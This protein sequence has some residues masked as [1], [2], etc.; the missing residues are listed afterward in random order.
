MNLHVL[1]LI[2]GI[3][4]FLYGIQ[5]ACY[6]LQQLAGSQLKV[7][8]SQLTHNRLKS[9]VTGMGV[10]ALL[11]SSSASSVLVV[12]FVGLGLM[13]FD[14]VL[15]FLLGAG[16]GS[17][18]T[19]QLISF[20]IGKYALLLIAVGFFISTVYK[21]MG[22]QLGMVIFG[23]GLVFFSMNLMG[24]ATLTF[25]ENKLFLDLLKFLA[26]SPF[27]AFIFAALFTAL[28]QGSAATLG[29]LI[30]LGSA[31]VLTLEE[32]IPFM[33][34]ANVGTCITA[35]IA[36]LKS[37]VKGRQV[38]FAFLFF[39]TSGALL[40][41]PF[42]FLFRD[43]VVWST[44]IAESV[45]GE[46]A[47]IAHQIAN[48]H[49]FFNFIN[50]LIFLPGLGLWGK[51]IQKIFPTPLKK[52]EFG[53]LYLDEGAISSPSFALGQATR[54]VLRVGE[55]V[56][57]ML[58]G[59]LQVLKVNDEELMDKINR[60][61]DK[62]DL[63]NRNIK[64]YLARITQ[65]SLTEEQACIEHELVSLSS[66][67]EHVGDTITKNILRIIEKKK[68]KQ[69]EFSKD[70]L[71]EIENFYDK[72]LENFKLS[73]SAFAMMDKQLSIKVL[74]NRQNIQDFE[75]ELREKHFQRLSEGQKSTILTTSLHLE[76]LTHLKNISSNIS[77]IAYL[78]VER[79]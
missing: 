60:D 37:S 3:C 56:Q 79:L 1:E 26:E 21:K 55:I 4:L 10:T 7:F 35:L 77:N 54:E 16:V 40:F 49:T 68:R 59:T 11:Q 25:K 36:S 6:H 57:K 2:G 27:F 20:K 43:F 58:G 48:A 53:P 44:S 73:L 19:A 63:L 45:M 5:I 64:F 22:R 28:I 61:D 12:S 24:D 14:Q 65:E 38:A 47:L 13:T 74:E 67:L 8:L 30:I 31:G 42:L 66:D 17:T 70:G 50:A 9:F 76:L 46:Q 34:G 69:V 29:V 51:L 75:F 18:I 62:V 32:S 52:Q 71:L 15:G 78:L 23:F 39:K 72:I 41:F 33:L